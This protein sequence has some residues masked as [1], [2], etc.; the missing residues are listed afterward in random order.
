M[1]AVIAMFALSVVCIAAA[2]EIALS[3]L[4]TP[5][6]HSDA[7]ALAVLVQIPEPLSPE[8]QALADEAEKFLREREV[9]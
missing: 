7:C 3:L 2:Q 9:A 8:G 5:G 6:Y 1:I 4:R